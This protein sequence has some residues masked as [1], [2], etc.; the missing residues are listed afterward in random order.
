MMIDHSPPGLDHG[1]FVSRPFAELGT[2]HKGR[3]N[4]GEEAAMS[5]SE[6]ID[7]EVERVSLGHHKTKP[8]RGYVGAMR[9]TS[10][11]LEALE[12]TQRDSPRSV[13]RAPRGGHRRRTV[14]PAKRDRLG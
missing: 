7:A 11:Y 10:L 2:G 14:G 12:K 4:R 5:T 6:S 3:A 1:L 8:V 13:G 9:D